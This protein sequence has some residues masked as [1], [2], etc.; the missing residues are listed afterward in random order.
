MVGPIDLKLTALPKPILL[1]IN[2]DL[3][4][5]YMANGDSG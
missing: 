5:I 1:N 3:N 2:K 4:L